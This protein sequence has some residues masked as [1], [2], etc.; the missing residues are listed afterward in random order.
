MPSSQQFP[1]GHFFMLDH[2]SVM[3]P[4]VRHWLPMSF[5]HSHGF[6]VPHSHMLKRINRPVAFSA[7]RIVEYASSALRFP[8]LHQS[9]FK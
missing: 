6:A 3:S 4:V 2:L 9:Y 5:A 8:V 7:S 1:S